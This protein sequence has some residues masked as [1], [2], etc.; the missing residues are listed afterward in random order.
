MRLRELIALEKEIGRP[1]DAMRLLFRQNRVVSSIVGD[2]DHKSAFEILT[3]PKLSEQY[4]GADDRR[5]FRRHVLWTRLLVDRRTTLPHDKEGDLLDY[6]RRNRE[7]LV[8]KPNR[9]YGGTGVMLGPAT[10]QA[11]WEQALQK[12]V[13]RRRSRKVLGGAGGDT[14]SSS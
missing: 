12:A 5:L 1:L 9:A 4:F 6:A 7:L 3:D 2:F 8:L 10:E 11:E 13:S 14:S